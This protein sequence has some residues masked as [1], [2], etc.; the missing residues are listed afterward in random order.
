MNDC[1]SQYYRCPER[2]L[3]FAL[4]GS[5]SEHS[6]YFRFGA[7]T[8]C[9]GKCSV[10]P[11]SASPTGILHDTLFDTTLDHGTTCL[12]FDLTQVVENLR[13]ELYAEKEGN[14]TGLRTQLNKAYYM[15]RPVLP[16]VVRKHL[17][18]WRLRNWDRLPFP[19][20]PVDR[21]VDRIFEQVMLLSLRSQPVDR[22]PFVWFWAQGA[23]SCAIMTHD[24]ETAAGRDA[25]SQLMDIDDSFG[26]KAA[27]EIIPQ[28]RYE[29]TPDFLE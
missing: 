20:W 24:V 10:H 7:G 9:Y 18:K 17:Q 1:V 23:T 8:V 11:P 28:A 29:V 6:G 4:R 15:V 21:T 19:Q 12:P 16:V 14:L 3:R 22:I 26:I 5:L 13:C 25:C 2:Y 27:F